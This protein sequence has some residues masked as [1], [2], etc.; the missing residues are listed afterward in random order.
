LIGSAGEMLKP[1]CL[2]VDAKALDQGR[3]WKPPSNG[4]TPLAG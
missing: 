2:T 1:E 4:S 3:R